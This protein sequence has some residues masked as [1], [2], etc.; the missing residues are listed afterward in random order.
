MGLWAL[1]LHGDTLHVKEDVEGSELKIGLF[2][3]VCTT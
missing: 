2:L 1:T 3:F